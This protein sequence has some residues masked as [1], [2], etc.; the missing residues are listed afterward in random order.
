MQTTHDG[1]RE[2]LAEWQNSGDVPEL[3]PRQRDRGSGGVMAI[4]E[5]HKHRIDA[6]IQM[7]DHQQV[8]ENTFR[9]FMIYSQMR[10]IELLE[11]QNTDR[12]D[13]IEE[14]GT[15]PRGTEKGK[16]R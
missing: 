10:I 16:K 8:N 3:R 11:E 6:E 9:M 2:E 1:A 14:R 13:I 4:T 7:R 15:I 5:L 12:E